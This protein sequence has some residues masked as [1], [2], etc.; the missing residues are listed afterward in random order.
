MNAASNRFYGTTLTKRL[1]KV[2]E[3]MEL[4]NQVKAPYGRK[5]MIVRSAKL[6]KALYGCEVAP[7]NERALRT[8]RARIAKTLAYTTEQRSTDLTFATCSNGPDLDPDIHIL[9]RRAVALRRF[10]TRH[11]GENEYE[12]GRS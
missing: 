5:A 8:L 12:G 6:P 7:V 9:A 11:E 10:I 3:E 2:A 4:L 1:E